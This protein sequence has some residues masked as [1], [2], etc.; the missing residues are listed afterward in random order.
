MVSAP[1]QPDQF[2]DWL[3]SSSPYIYAHRGCTFVVLF[4]GEAVADPGFSHLIHDLALLHGLGIR[5]VLVHGARPQIEARLR[6]RGA[7]LHYINGLRVTDAAALTC[8]KE[9]A[10]TV[11]VEIEALLSMGLANS[12]MAGV[13]IRVASGNFVTARP[14]GVRDGVD[15]CH[16]G[17]VRR[18]DA[19]ALTRRLDSGAIALVPP[20]GYSPTGEVFNLSAADVAT[21]AATALGADKLIMLVEGK[22]LTDGHGHPVPDLLPR[23]VE[24]LLHGRRKLPEDLRHALEG[25]VSACRGG[26][27]RVHLLPRQTD[28]VLLHELF[29]REGVGTLLTAEPYEATRTARIED[30]GGVLELLA[31]LEDKGMLVRRSRELLDTE[32]ERFTVV[33]RDAMVIACAALYPY[34]AEQMGELAC[35]AVHPQYRNSGRGEALLGRMEAK[36]REARDPPDI[37]AQHPD[38]PL[39]PGARLCQCPDRGT[40]DGK[41]PAVQLPPQFQGHHQGPGLRAIA[42]QSGA[43]RGASPGPCRLTWALSWGTASH[44]PAGI[45]GTAL[46]CFPAPAERPAGPRRLGCAV[47]S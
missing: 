39:V 5:L 13:R 9:A 29:T 1:G 15:Y 19:D 35:L 34:L 7:A 28:G 42:H 2:V 20:I 22:G 46:A 32:I 41:A 23:D 27:K 11:R 3:R 33:E 25:A 16:T 6:E 8:V 44:Q 17:V 40:A 26:V 47:I 10:G 18:I 38:R 21:S 36:A 4:G 24:Q 37:R 31:P 45:R 30:V 14:I 43:D 12:P